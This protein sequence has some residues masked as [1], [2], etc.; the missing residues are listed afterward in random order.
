[1][2]KKITVLSLVL[3][4]LVSHLTITVAIDEDEIRRPFV[5]GREQNV[6]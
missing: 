3:W 1:M 2:M 4:L 5:P 6:F